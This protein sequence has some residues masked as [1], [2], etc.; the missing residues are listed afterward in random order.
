ML[1][2]AAVL[3]LVVGL[4][5]GGLGGGGGVLTVP[6]LV[7]LLGQSAQDATTAS[8]VI[9]GAASL[10]GAA[11][12][13]RGGI[14]WRTALGFGIAGI[15][16]AYL[17]T[18]L[19]HRTAGPVLLL[20]FAGLVLVVAAAMLLRGRDAATEEPAE[21]GEPAGEAPVPAGGTTVVSRPATRRGTLLRTT[22]EILL[23]G[24][25]VGFLT[26]FLGV[27]GGFLVVPALVIVLR[28]PMSLA[29]GTSL[30]IIVL[31]SVSSVGS[32]IGALDL[33]WRV[34]LPF[35]VAAVAGTLLGKRVA[36]RFSGP[37]LERAFAVM[38][39]GVGLFVGV[40]SLLAL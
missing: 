37:T 30:L 15:P 21:T 29:V 27:G 20:V 26:G 33:D 36:G 13:M 35:A 32:R 39:A 18:L 28:M 25:A 10:A 22:A 12:R 38:L 3:G 5:I 6:A 23:C 2:A 34:V 8:V 17:G 1:A 16:A 19:N 14:D 31:N 40:Q 7:Y 9:V 11:S 24:G 4:V